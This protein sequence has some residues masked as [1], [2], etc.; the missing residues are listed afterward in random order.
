MYGHCSLLLEGWI[1]LKIYLVG[2]ALRD[3]LLGRSV[4]EK[5]WVVVGATPQQ[6]LDLG[7][8]QVGKD[9]PVFLHPESGEE[10]ALART[11]RSIAPGYQ[12]FEF[13]TSP[14]VT[15]EEDLLRRDLTINAMARDDHGQLTDPYH[16]V[17]DIKA[18]C[19]R[20][21]SPAFSEDPVRILRIA[22]FKAR[23][24]YLGFQIAEETMELMRSMVAQGEVNTLVAER[25]WQEL[26]K[27]L[28]EEHP[29]VFFNVLRECGALNILFPELDQLYGIA[30]DPERHPEKDAAIHYLMVLEQSAKLTAD[31]MVRFS[32]LLHDVGKGEDNKNHEVTGVHLIRE[33]C[34][35]FRI[36]KEYRE[37]AVLVCQYHND[38]HSAQALTAEKSLHLLERC[39]A[40]RRPQRFAQ[41]LLAC[42]ADYCGRAGC[43][44]KAYEQKHYWNALIGVIGEISVQPLLEKGLEGKAI[45]DELHKLR[46]CAIEEYLKETPHG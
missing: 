43:A 6:M 46:I 29:T 21:V 4:T 12:G 13:N 8:R 2:G 44:S 19:L 41:F 14:D 27:A 9:F 18:R 25:V 35:R 17:N 11:E 31:V 38:C 30:E 32:A 39:D 42:E 28:Q 34:A 5:D 40:L 15:L 26:H 36:P 33:L 20:H 16:G 45:A 1:A 3:E 24:H 37:L 7:Y 22:R 23:Y 10:Y